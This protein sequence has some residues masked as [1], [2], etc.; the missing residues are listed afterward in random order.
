MIHDFNEKL[1]FSQG[2]RRLTD[3]MI[4]KQAIPGCVE[5]RKTGYKEDLKGVDYV[6]VLKG[7][8]EIGIDAKARE[9]GASKYWKTREAELALE[10]WSVFPCGENTSKIGWTLSDSSNVDLILYTFDPSDWDKCYL[11]P[12]Q[13]LRIAFIRNR[14]DW[15]KRYSKKMQD[16][17]NWYSQALFVPASVVLKAINLVEVMHTEILTV[18]EGNKS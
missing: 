14:E 6:A 15:E 13:M 17:G 12:Y 11:L 4:L 8:A 7:G 1:A 5:V 2:A 3:L 18:K 10:I 16:S 9:R